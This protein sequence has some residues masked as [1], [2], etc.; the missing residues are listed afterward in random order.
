MYLEVLRAV[1]T[2]WLHH[3][4]RILGLIWLLRRFPLGTLVSS[5]NPRICTFRLMGDSKFPR[6]RVNTM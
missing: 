2:V 5:H 1:N 4:M 6:V 3:S